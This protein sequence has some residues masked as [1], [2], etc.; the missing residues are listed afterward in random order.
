MTI[1]PN[2]RFTDRRRDRRRRSSAYYAALG[3][4]SWL[5]RERTRARTTGRPMSLRARIA[6]WRETGTWQA[7]RKTTRRAHHN[8][9]EE[10]QSCTG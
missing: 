10:Q 8:V 1:N 6:E 2:V 3:R 5:A 9:R 4:K 7:A